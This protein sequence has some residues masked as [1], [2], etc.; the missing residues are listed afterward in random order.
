[1]QKYNRRSKKRESRFFGNGKSV[2]GGKCWVNPLKD[3]VI[4]LVPT[5]KSPKGDLKLAVNQ[6]FAIQI[7]KKVLILFWITYYKLV[8]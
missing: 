8:T 1:M 2:N 6:Y 3:T 4:W 5:P 7:M